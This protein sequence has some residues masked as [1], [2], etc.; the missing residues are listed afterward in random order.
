MWSVNG[1]VKDDNVYKHF[2]NCDHEGQVP[3][4]N[5]VGP[6]IVIVQENVSVVSVLFFYATFLARKKMLTILCFYDIISMWLFIIT[7]ALELEM[8][9]QKKIG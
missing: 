6:K 3:F 4:L 2:K 8:K 5:V 1:Q 9:Q 7:C